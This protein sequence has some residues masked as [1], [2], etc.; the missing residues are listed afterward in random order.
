M[1]DQAASRIELEDGRVLTKCDQC[2]TAWKERNERGVIGD[3]PCD[4]CRIGLMPENEEA[5]TIYMTVRGQVITRG[6]DGVVTDINHLAIDA[7][8]ERNEVRDR[9]RVFDQV[10]RAFHHFLR[11]SRNAG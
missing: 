3:P 8:M 7:A 1:D 9:K 6:M 4:T 11:E 2:I 10:V 5:A